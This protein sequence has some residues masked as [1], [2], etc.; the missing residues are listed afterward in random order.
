MTRARKSVAIPFTLAALLGLAALS[1]WIFA[2]ESHS[3]APAA[4]NNTYS[5]FAEM[6]QCRRP[7]IFI[8]LGWIAFILAI[9]LGWVGG[10]RKRRNRTSSDAAGPRNGGAPPHDAHPST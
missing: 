6:P 3:F 7:A 8:A 9:A 1:A 4:C 10:V 5:L 2:I